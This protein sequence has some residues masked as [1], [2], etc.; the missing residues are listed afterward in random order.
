[1]Y[2]T[3]HLRPRCARA[4]VNACSASCGFAPRPSAASNAPAPCSPSLHV[5]THVIET[6]GK[7]ERF[8]QCYAGGG[9]FADLSCRS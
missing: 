9:A 5:D 8:K 2:A 6:L 1:M 3:T 7:L 4:T